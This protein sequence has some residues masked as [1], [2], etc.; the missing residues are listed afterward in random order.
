MAESAQALGLLKRF[1]SVTVLNGQIHQVLQK[2]ERN[3]TFHR[4]YST[5]L[6]RPA[7]GTATTP[8]PLAAPAT[9][10]RSMP[11]LHSVSYRAGTGALAIVDATRE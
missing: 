8:G 5:A 6:P 9:R 11:G 7:P 3:V 2:V 10:P 1:G 4:A